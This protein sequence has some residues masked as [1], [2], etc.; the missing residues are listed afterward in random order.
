M[1]CAESDPSSS[2]LLKIAPPTMRSPSLVRRVN[3]EPVGMSGGVLPESVERK[4]M[5]RRPDGMTSN[6]ELMNR[7]SPCSTVKDQPSANSSCPLANTND[8]VSVCAS[9]FQPSLYS[10]LTSV[11]DQSGIAPSVAVAGVGS[12]GSKFRRSSVN[13]LIVT[14]KDACV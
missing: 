13:G 1:T 2:A 8:H 11:S 3:H 5:R 4:T 10:S 7:E 6:F 12:S 9:S 14:E